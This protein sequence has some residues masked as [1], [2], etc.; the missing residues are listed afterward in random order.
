MLA[1]ESVGLIHEILPA[2]EVVKKI[3]AEA[4]ALLGPAPHVDRLS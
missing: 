1:G 3:A 2:A 4:E